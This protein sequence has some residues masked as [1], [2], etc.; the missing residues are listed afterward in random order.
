MMGRGAAGDTE[1][2]KHP[3]CS[4]FLHLIEEALYIQIILTHSRATKA[5]GSAEAST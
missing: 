4:P 1:V 2:T 3:S 5:T